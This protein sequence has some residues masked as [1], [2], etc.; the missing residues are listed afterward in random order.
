MFQPHSSTYYIL[1]DSRGVTRIPLESNSSYEEAH[2]YRIWAL[3]DTKPDP[4]LW[5]MN[6]FFVQATSPKTENFKHFRKEMKTLTYYMPLW[7]WN[8]IRYVQYVDSNLL[9]RTDSHKILQLAI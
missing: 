6:W 4:R 1:F 8:E 2:D 7:T 9:L 5:T 3:I